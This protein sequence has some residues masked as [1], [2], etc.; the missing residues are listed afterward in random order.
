MEEYD[1]LAPLKQSITEQVAR[2]YPGE[3]S[4]LDDA[5]EH[6]LI[7]IVYVLGAWECI[8]DMKVKRALLEFIIS[9]GDYEHRI[10]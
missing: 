3:V 4:E 2:L 8:D 6:S 9:R 10:S 5:I 7:D 1:D